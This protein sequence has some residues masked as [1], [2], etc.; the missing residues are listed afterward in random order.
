MSGDALRRGSGEIAETEATGSVA[1]SYS[2][3]R[4]TLGVPFVP[5]VFRMLARY[6]NFLEAGLRGLDRVDLT[7]LA[8]SGRA[9]GERAARELAGARLDA[10]Q[11]RSSVVTLLDDYNRTNPRG[12]VVVSAMRGPTSRRPPAVMCPP[13]PA[14]VPE[15]LDDVRACHG[16]LT[17]PGLW[18][19]LAAGHPEVA[20]SG[21]A[22]VRPLAEAPAFAAARRAI[23]TDAAAAVS[24]IR[25]PDPAALGL[26]A[27]ATHEVT[28][29]LDWFFAAIPTLIVEIEV[30]RLGVQ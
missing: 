16:G 14:P 30:L 17:V 4:E 19:E 2:Q 1:E 27:A 12:I 25:P 10:G 15:L 7:A 8:R 5:T 11:D 6:P 21:W 26:D 24:A 20:A 23:A 13:L 18:R 9:H 22:Q 28:E 29:I 3:L